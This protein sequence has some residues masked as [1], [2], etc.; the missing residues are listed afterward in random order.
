M[1]ML[2]FSFALSLN[3]DFKYGW[4]NDLYTSGICQSV[5]NAKN[6][7]CAVCE[8]LCLI[9]CW[10][11]KAVHNRRKSKYSDAGDVSLKAKTSHNSKL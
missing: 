1:H 6:E 7:P 2:S 4:F 9:A 11:K 3:A 10:S 8:L 5:S